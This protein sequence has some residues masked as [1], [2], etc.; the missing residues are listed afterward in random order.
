MNIS[1]LFLLINLSLIIGGVVF[2]TR[3]WGSVRSLIVLRGVGFCLF[4]LVAI[5]SLSLV[6]RFTVSVTT[7]FGRVVACLPLLLVWLILCF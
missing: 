6:I 3:I 7:A 4:E 1:R 2:D 5:I